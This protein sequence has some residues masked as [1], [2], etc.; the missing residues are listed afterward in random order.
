MLR[1][2]FRRNVAMLIGVVLAGQLLAGLLVQIWVIGP[3]TTRVA[4]VTA[5]MIHALST[6]V[7]NLL[8]SAERQSSPTSATDRIC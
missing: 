6:T 7:G 2:L 8:P 1:R 4:D 5:D 3:Q